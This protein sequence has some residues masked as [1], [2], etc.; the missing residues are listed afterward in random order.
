MTA[1]EK[2][3]LQSLNAHLA[4][5]LD[6]V[7]ALEEA[8]ADLE[9]KIWE[10]YDKQGP[11]SSPKDY[12]YYDAIEGLKNQVG[13]EVLSSVSLSVTHLHTHAVFQKGKDSKLRHE[14][15]NASLGHFKLSSETGLCLASDGPMAGSLA[16][17]LNFHVHVPTFQSLSSAGKRPGFTWPGLGLGVGASSWHGS[18]SEM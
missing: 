13:G 11:K 6:K 3:T 7:Q 5:Y 10:R 16:C 1:D 9:N 12:S 2:N 18:R 15:G 4:F 17:A 14:P 8:R